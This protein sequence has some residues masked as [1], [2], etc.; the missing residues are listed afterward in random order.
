[1]EVHGAHGYL[2]SQFFCADVN[3]RTDAYGGSLENRARMAVE[4]V[5][6]IKRACG[7]AFVVSVRMGCNEPDV[8]GSVALGRLLAQAGADLL[9]ISN[10]FLPSDTLP[11]GAAGVCVFH[12]G[13]IWPRRCARSCRC[14][15]PVWAACAR[16][17]RQRRFAAGP[18]RSGGRGARPAERRTVCQ[19]GARADAQPV[20]GLQALSVVYRWAQV[21]GTAARN[22]PA[23]RAGA[24][25][26]VLSAAFPSV[27]QLQRFPCIFARS[28]TIAACMHTLS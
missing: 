7:S 1:M 13:C 5:S 14:P 6:G 27:G 26:A 11:P 28:G 23:P 2:L 10:G 8:A 3:R 22:P 17:S 12:R 18:G 9:D 24:A 21:P 4:I 15:L 16:R 25:H 20:P 19:Q